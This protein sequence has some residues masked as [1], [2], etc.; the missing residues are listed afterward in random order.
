MIFGSLLIDLLS[1]IG[2]VFL[3]GVL[4]ITVIVTIGIV[5]L[6]I[7]FVIAGIKVLLGIDK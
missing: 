3:I 7:G 2:V 1:A 4:I 5:A 6:G